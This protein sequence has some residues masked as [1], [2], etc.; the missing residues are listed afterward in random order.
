MLVVSGTPH[1]AAHGSARGGGAGPEV[2]TRPVGDPRPAPIR[3]SGDDGDLAAAAKPAP[4]DAALEA[5]ARTG[6]TTFIVQLGS[7]PEVTSQAAGAPGET[8]TASGDGVSATP[9]PATRFA[10][11]QATRGLLAEGALRLAALDRTVA[12]LEQRGAVTAVEP[13]PAFGMLAVTGNAE[14]VATL[15]RQPGVAAIRANRG[16][17]LTALPQAVASADRHLA[18]AGGGWNLTQVGAPLVWS[19]LGATGEGVVVAVLDTGVDWHHPALASAYR[20]RSGEHHYHWLDATRTQGADIEPSDPHGHGTHV[21]GLIAGREGARAYGVAPGA[22]WIAARVFDGQGE[23][24]DLVLLRGAAWLL[25]P[26]RIDGSAPRLDLAPDIV[27]C[28]WDLDNGADPLFEPVIDAWRAAGIL[29]VFAAG[30]TEGDLAGPNRVL[31]PASDPR[32]LAVG[33]LTAERTLWWRSRRGPGFYGGVKPDLVAPGAGILSTWPEGQTAYADGTSMATPHVAGAAAL[34]LSLNPDLGGDDLAT[35]LRATAG[36][37]GAAGPDPEHG[38]G[39]LDAYAAGR[40]ALETGHIA[41]QVLGAA[42]EPLAGAT[43]TVV[44]PAGAHAD[45]R[46]EARADAAGRYRLAL[47]AGAWHAVATAFGAA[48]R[49]QPVTVVA[50]QTLARD[51]RLDPASTA[52]LAGRLISAAGAPLVDGRVGVVGQTT[53]A[54]AASDGTFAIRLPFGRHIVRFAARDHRVVTST[55][56]ISS[57]APAEEPV[58]LPTA[59]RILLVDADAWDGERIAPYLGRALD[60]AGYA[61][62]VWT[63]DDLARPPS[64]GDLAAHDLVIWAHSNNSPGYLDMLRGDKAATQALADYV[65]RGGRLIVSGQDVGALDARQPRRSGLAPVFFE[66]VLGAAQVADTPAGSLLLHGAGPLAGLELDLGWPDGAEKVRRGIRPDVVA[67][68]PDAAPEAVQPIL[69]YPDDQ[70]AALATSDAGG[71]RVYLAF[72]PESAGGR[73][74]LARLFDRLIG[75]LEPPLVALSAPAA[76]VAPGATVPLTLTV[77]TGR[78]PAPVEITVD[79][80]AALAAEPS[81][82]GPRADGRGWR[83]S[84]LLDA[85]EV[86]RFALTA[87]LTGPAAGGQ[88]LPITATVRSA[89]RSALA[90]TSLRP[91]APDLDASLLAISPDRRAAGGEVSLSLHLVNSGPASASAA[92]ARVDL[93]AGLRPITPTLTATAGQAAWTSERQ[94]VW[95]GA[96]P[97]GEPAEL[98]V[99]AEAP[100]GLGVEHVISVLLDDGAGRR[101]SRS[102]AIL[103][104][105]P[106]LG[107]SRLDEVPATVLAGMAFTASLHV[108]NTGP[109]PADAR[110]EVELPPD[111]QLAGPD[112]GWTLQPPRAPVEPQAAA[113]DAVWT[114][115]VAPGAAVDVPLPLA[116]QAGAASGGREL[117][118]RLDDGRLPRREISLPAALDLRRAELAASRVILWPAAPRSGGVLSATILV[119]NFGDA[120]AEVDLVDALSPALVPLRSSV[121]A[122]TGKAT[123]QPGTVAWE[124]VAVPPLRADYGVAAGPEAVGGTAVD[125]PDDPRA[126]RPAR[127][128]ATAADARPG[129]HGPFALDLA[130]PFYTEVYTQAWATDDGRLTFTP[131]GSDTSAAFDPGSVG[132]PVIAP[133]YQARSA[134]AP[135]REV[136]VLRGAGAVTV[137]WSIASA[138]SADSHV[139]AVLDEAGALRFGYGLAVDASGA[140]AGLRA[141]DGHLLEIPSTY[142][143]PGRSV[144]LDPPGGWARLTFQSRVGNAVEANGRVSHVARLRG[145][146]REHLLTAGVR[147]NRLRLD[148]SLIEVTPSMPL[149]GSV[150]RYGAHLIASGDI[151]AR[152]VELWIDVPDAVTLDPGSLSTGLSYDPVADVLRWRGG[153]SPGEPRHFTWS[154]VVD[155]DLP[156]GARI[157]TRAEIRPRLAGVPTARLVHAVRVQTSDLS[158]STKTASPPV[159][160]PGETVM[161]TL[162]AANAGPAATEVELSDALPPELTYQEGSATSSA[163]GAPIWDAVSRTLRWRGLVPAAGAVE[164]R[165][166]ARYAGPGPVTNVLRV[167]DTAGAHFAAWAEVYPERARLYL[168]RVERRR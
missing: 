57:P 153:L 42:G 127:L 25:A 110:A 111:I 65:A 52:L 64:A 3:L 30:N 90:T 98:R 160:R 61:F 45:W 128:V 17:R 19:R 54:A 135:P 38:W 16:H 6:P 123:L 78:A 162:R 83:W 87:R 58:V 49:S 143:R 29:P 89:G 168:P 113:R 158:G 104:G 70:A 144:E 10:R 152:D 131:P 81:G 88:S 68:A 166:A 39:G 7:T 121:R 20:G 115:P 84:G 165:F 82:P 133:L 93:P 91:L 47:P 116:V 96:L 66:R 161:F 15:A 92:S 53:V 14:A 151:P 147:A 159:A 134:D 125:S 120:P 5:A 12:G 118:V 75:W 21:T 9:P 136:E 46:W 56:D 100:D 157:V 86:H 119:A 80:P 60:D 27:N 22:E 50:G 117:R 122:S 126:A 63:L 76:P 11:V 23:T 2:Q 155:P 26:T 138:E 137:T 85:D 24:T 142:V 32:A 108:A 103:V 35:L 43:V 105:G 109:A 164:L 67:P 163:G 79:L 106:D 148:G 34:L 149:P 154:A 140:R 167:A 72:G 55:V 51:F 145:A 101:I 37:L 28:S 156:P 71:R 33:A 150:L 146:G 4:V 99:T 44:A 41:G 69:R 1:S 74:A 8:G 59:P 112:T 36:D 97:P 141:P 94:I 18:P 124:L 95:Q 132:A 129:V 107:A 62:A 73:L 130:F 13:F 40:L 102:A 77:R 139:Y 48:P 31:A 114:G